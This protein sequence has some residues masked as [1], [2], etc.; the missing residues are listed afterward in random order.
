MAIV[1]QFL[2]TLSHIFLGGLRFFESRP[3][4]PF[5]LS[6]RDEIGAIAIID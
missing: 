4:G 1:N 5:K 2:A 3:D 6:L